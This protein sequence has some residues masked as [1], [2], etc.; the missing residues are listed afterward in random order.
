MVT[1]NVIFTLGEIIFALFLFSFDFMSVHI[2]WYHAIMTSERSLQL[3]LLCE[4]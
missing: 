2:F 1:V 4:H 3:V